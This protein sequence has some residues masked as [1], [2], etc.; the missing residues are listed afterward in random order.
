LTS[1]NWNCRKWNRRW[2]G[3][4]IAYEMVGSWRENNL[5]FRAYFS[6]ARA[7]KEVPLNTPRVCDDFMWER[8][9]LCPHFVSCQ[10]QGRLWCQTQCERSQMTQELQNRL[11]SQCSWVRGSCITWIFINSKFW[12]HIEWTC[13]NWANYM[14]LKYC[15]LGCLMILLIEKN[16]A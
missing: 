16:K 7:S 6:K 9:P 14:S 8:S 12:G 4:C 2:E 10:A 3:Y 13:T 11:E 5:I 15:C 1:S